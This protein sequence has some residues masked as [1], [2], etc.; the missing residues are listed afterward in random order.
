MRAWVLLT[1]AGLASSAAA[2]A[3]TIGPNCSTCFGGTYTL[4]RNFVG[5]TATTETW[6]FTYTLDTR[7][8]NINNVTYVGSIAAKVSSSLDSTLT[9]VK[10][11]GGVWTNPAA[12]TNIS[13]SG[14]DGSGS[15]WVCIA[16]NS[17]TQLLTGAAAPAPYSWVFEVTANTGAFLSEASI[18]AN[19]DPANGKIL[20]ESIHVPEGMPYELPVLLSGLGLWMLV[21]VRSKRRMSSLIN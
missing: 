21:Q 11:T 5:S 15:G 6:Q 7:N 13:N 16:W 4:D 18:Q 8:V 3:G 2:S 1:L 9:D 17:G 19:F 12:N 20:S 10:P 14:C